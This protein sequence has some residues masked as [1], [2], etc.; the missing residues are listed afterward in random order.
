MQIPSNMLMS[1][2]KIRPSI[3]MAGCMAGWAIVAALTALVK[4]YTGLV[5]VRFFLGVLEAPFCLSP[6]A[7]CIELYWC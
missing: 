5:L 7:I 1:S 6:I 2:R 3:Y 4:N